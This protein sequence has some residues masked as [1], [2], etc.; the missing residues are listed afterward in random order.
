MLKADYTIPS[1]YKG[2]TQRGPQSHRTGAGLSTTVHASVP[3]S[4]GR[5]GHRLTLT[6]LRQAGVLAAREV[7][8]LTIVPPLQG[9][10]ILLSGD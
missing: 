5:P 7:L 9:T 6:F 10:P 8:A 4:P 2:R 1:L 3:G